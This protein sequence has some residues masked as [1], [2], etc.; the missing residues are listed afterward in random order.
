MPGLTFNARVIAATATASLVEEVRLAGAAAG[1]GFV[2]KA[3]A[4]AVALEQLDPRR[5]DR[6]RQEM[7][8]AGGGVS[9][10]RR[11]PAAET[12]E[13]GVILI[14]SRGQFDALLAR[15]AGA[16]GDLAAV[17]TEVRA[18][19]DGYARR[20]FEI[21]M[22][23]RRL[24]VGPGPAIMGVVNVTPD[25]FSD[26]GRY[27]D[28]QAAIDHARRLIDEGADIL[29]IGGESTR[30]GSDPVA[31]EEEVARVMPVIEALAGSA[32]IAI[33]IDTRRPRVARRAVAAGACLVNDVTGL[34]GD[35]AMAPAVAETG[36][37]VVVMHMLGDP[38]TMQDDPRYDN[39]MADVCRHLRRGLAIAREAGVAE[40]ATIV[41]PGIGFG[42][43]LEH[44]VR[45][46]ARLGQLR[47]LGRP[48]LVGPSRKRF[49]GQLAGIES[50]AERTFGTAAACALA[51]AAGALLVR[52]HDVRPV[53][54]ALAVAA[55]IAQAADGDA[56]A[57]V[58]GN[59]S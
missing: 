14:G 15:L 34:Q 35:P 42:K 47:S 9:V 59:A 22:G 58:A 31:E 43:T 6:L 55:A 41:D 53:R 39:L 23:A 10:C 13:A 19:L 25:S 54:Q 50:P 37:G 36:A 32:G 56:T 51:V 24:A 49:I 38:K 12:R 7:I 44:N 16:A 30:P 28:R 52:V 5:A 18:A 3:G 1:N 46:L 45:L 48:V 4:M 20:R 2:G 29:D 40:D 8:A 26:G 17:G 57:P 21:R 11:G 33:S 27:F